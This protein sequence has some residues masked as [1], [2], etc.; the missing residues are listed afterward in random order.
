MRLDQSAVCFE[1]L[2]EELPSLWL[3]EFAGLTDEEIFQRFDHLLYTGPLD[4]IFDPERAEQF[5][6]FNFLTNWGEHTDGFKGYL[7]YHPEGE[8]GMMIRLPDDSLV[9]RRIDPDLF[10]HV[11]KGFV[12]WFRQES[13]RLRPED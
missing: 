1:E 6:R 10:V 13:A 7:I 2:V 4:M 12:D 8:V 9:C 5:W 3:K 11:A